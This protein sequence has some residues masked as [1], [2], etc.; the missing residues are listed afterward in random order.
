MSVYEPDMLHVDPPL[1]SQWAISKCDIDHMHNTN[2]ILS[3]NQH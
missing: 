2:A 1:Y 3:G